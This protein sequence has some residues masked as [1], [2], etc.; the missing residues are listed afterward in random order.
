MTPLN[1][2]KGIHTVNSC[3]ID[4]ESDILYLTATGKESGE[5]SE[6]KNYFLVINADDIA[7]DANKRIHSISEYSESTSKFVPSYGISDSG[8][9]DVFILENDKIKSVKYLS[10]YAPTINVDTD[11]L[12]EDTKHKFKVTVTG[13]TPPDP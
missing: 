3:F 4:H 13:Y 12:K 2:Y 11:G 7:L 1:A 9:V 5:S 8:V 10:I 6:N